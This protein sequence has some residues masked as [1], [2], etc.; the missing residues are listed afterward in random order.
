MEFTVPANYFRDMFT[1]D[2]NISIMAFVKF[3]HTNER[4]YT[5]QVLTLLKPVLSIEKVPQKDSIAADDEQFQISMI[6]STNISLTNC[7]IRIDGT[8]LRFHD[9]PILCGSI[10][11]YKTL[12]VITNA[13][14]RTNFTERKI[15]AV[16]NC[17]Q[18]KNVRT[19]FAYN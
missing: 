14:K 11:A 17:D 6:N 4:F 13:I 2:W 5:E 16:L 3:L 19:Y 10:E 9:S 12:S 8:G 1:E 18:L 15:V 7:E